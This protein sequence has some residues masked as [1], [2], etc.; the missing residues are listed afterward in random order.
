M[1]D[2]IICD[3]CGKETHDT[4]SEIMEDMVTGKKSIHC[5]DCDPADEWAESDE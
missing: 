1:S 3:L 5:Y 4:E 2:Q